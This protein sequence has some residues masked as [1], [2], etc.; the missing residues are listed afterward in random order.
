S[1]RSLDAVAA[2]VEGSLA[3]LTFPLEYHAEVRTESI[4]EEAGAARVVGF[5][6]ACFIAMFLL[7]QALF[8]SWR[9]AALVTVLLPLG[10]VG[11]LVAMAFD[12]LDLTLGAMAGLL[13]VFGLAARLDLS[14]V[15]RFRV[16]EEE[17]GYPGRADV[18]KRVAREK[19]APTVTST[20]AVAM[21]ALPFIVLGTRP[22]LEIAHP[23]AIVFLGAL[24]TS[25]ATT[26]FVLPALYLQLAPT[27]EPQPKDI[28]EPAAMP[29]D[30]AGAAP[31][32][33]SAQ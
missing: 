16:L 26:L 7:L 17:G 22:G 32:Q 21:L 30:L 11:G 19:L 18:V 23:M 27:V 33:G 12:G 14:L 25:T 10:L 5:A 24:I 1:G 15:H 6:V 20:L 28:E 8:G 3:D 31:A 2:D 29:A 13:A 4:S 9:L